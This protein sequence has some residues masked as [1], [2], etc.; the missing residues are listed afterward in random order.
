MVAQDDV[1]VS[2]H[3][4]WKMLLLQQIFSMHLQVQKVELVL[5]AFLAQVMEGLLRGDLPAHFHQNQ[6]EVILE[7]AHLIGRG[8]FI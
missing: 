6:L 5:Q 2:K 4:L 7:K 3:F 1:K 8:T